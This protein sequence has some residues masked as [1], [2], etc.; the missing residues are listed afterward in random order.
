MPFMNKAL[1]KEIMTRTRLELDFLKDRNEEN[2]MKYSKQCNYCV[3]LLGQSKS[4]YFGN[5][6]ER[7]INDNKIFWKNIKSLTTNV[8]HHIKTSQLMR[9]IGRQWVK[10]FLSDEVTSANKMTLIDKKEIILGDYNTA[11]VLNTF[12]LTLSVTL[13]S[14]DTR[15]ER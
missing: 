14:Q 9:N 13:I 15:T 7:N 5:L 8:A 10:P 6:K 12:F 11:K 4:D 2:K 1:W 3:L